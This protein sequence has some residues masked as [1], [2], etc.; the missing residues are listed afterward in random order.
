MRHDLLM[1]IP[2]RQ[3]LALITAGGVGLGACAGLFS[4]RHALAPGDTVPEVE[5][6]NQD[7]GPVRLSQY[8]GRPLVVYFYPKDRT[9]G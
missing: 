2:L 5:A 9:S 8:R 1:S 3:T 6:R 4:R 7:G